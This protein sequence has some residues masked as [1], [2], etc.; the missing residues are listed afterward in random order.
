[1]RGAICALLA[2]LLAATGCGNRDNR[3][4]AT[5]QA[6]QAQALPPKT[7]SLAKGADDGASK[8]RL[9]AQLL[10]EHPLPLVA[11]VRQSVSV[12]GQEM[13]GTG[14]YCQMPYA[15]EKALVGMLSRMDLRLQIHDRTAIW[16]Q[17]CDGK[18]IWTETQVPDEE[19]TAARLDG[20]TGYSTRLDRVELAEMAEMGAL[21]R[22]PSR[23]GALSGLPHLLRTIAGAFD[24]A[25]PRAIRIGNADVW[26]LEG[27]WDPG[28]LAELLPEQ[29]PAAALGQIDAA[30]LPSR[31]PDRVKVYLGQNRTGPWL[32]DLAAR[33]A[34]PPD[35]FAFRIEYG[36]EDPE[37]GE[38][39]QVL[40]LEIVDVFDDENIR[41]DRFTFVPGKR[42]PRNA[43]QRFVRALVRG[44]R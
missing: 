21:P 22:G 13:R 40:G 28:V 14:D 41:A 38:V 44:A 25:P 34:P 42:K 26:L 32:G 8:L 27:R 20:K 17:V 10:E 33:R 18:F 35:L 24:F 19:K 16:K 4:A 1:M 23:A 39:H 6:G 37:T 36:R 5:Q 11:K 12:L 9:S 15:G 29:R 31:V 3:A 30:L 43:T 7:A 2:M